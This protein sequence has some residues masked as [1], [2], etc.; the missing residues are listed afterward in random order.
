MPTL[1]D[2]VRNWNKPPTAT[3]PNEPVRLDLQ[4]GAIFSHI[5]VCRF[6]EDPMLPGYYP[7]MTWIPLVRWETAIASV[8]QW[9][10]SRGFLLN[11]QE[12]LGLPNLYKTYREIRI[13][14]G[15]ICVDRNWL[16]YYND[17]RAE[18]SHTI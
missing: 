6:K 10:S 1:A 11:E 17:Q 18:K 15:A 13:K 12:I 5:A 4:V 8:R 9:C 2:V 7:G 16:R 3:Y 14:T